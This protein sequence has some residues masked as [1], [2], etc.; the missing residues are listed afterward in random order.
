MG[1]MTMISAEAFLAAAQAIEKKAP[2]Y[3]HGGTGADGT[4]DC[5]GLVI[6]AIR[7]AGGKY[8]GVHGSN[9][10]ARE[11]IRGQLYSTVSAKSLRPGM[12]VFKHYDPFDDNYD[13]P[14][15]YAKHP[16]QNDY[17]HVGIVLSAAPL[18]ILHCTKTGTV[19][20][21]TRST[22]LKG[23]SHYGWMKQ[24]GDG[25]EEESTMR[26]MTVRTDGGALNI[27]AAAS[28]NSE[29]VGKIPNGSTVEAG[30]ILNGWAPVRWNGI[31]GYCSAQY[32]QDA[33]KITISISRAAAEEL[34]AALK[35]M[36]G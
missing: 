14:T 13:L 22:S 35:Q 30:D 24:V 3:R 9:W 17:Y 19:N 2:T 10:A 31:A 8:T 29:R 1:V 34:L 33:D 28:T 4:C 27:R 26:I 25:Q 36:E 18:E 16:D 15:R 5:I 32:L 11:E 21:C 7:L 20:G 23:W 12:V 6:G